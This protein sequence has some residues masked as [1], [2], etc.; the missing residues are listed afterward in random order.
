MIRATVLHSAT[1]PTIIDVFDTL[2]SNSPTDRSTGCAKV[3]NAATERE[4][5]ATNKIAN[6]DR[7]FGTAEIYT[8]EFWSINLINRGATSSLQ[9]AISSEIER[10]ATQASIPP[11]C[12]RI[13]ADPPPFSLSY[14]LIMSRLSREIYVT[15]SNKHVLARKRTEISRARAILT[16][17]RKFRFA[18]FVFADCAND[19]SLS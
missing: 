13:L 17:R 7:A 4:M 12:P 16:T 18:P 10:S 5:R 11:V 2:N 8:A 1:Q 6:Y 15:R 9:A 19:A 3:M 14:Q